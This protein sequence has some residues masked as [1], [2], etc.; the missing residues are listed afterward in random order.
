MF[1]ISEAH[2]E[3]AEVEIRGA[4]LNDIIYVCV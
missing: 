4:C 1:I 2:N 3:R